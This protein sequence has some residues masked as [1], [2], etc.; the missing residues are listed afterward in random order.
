MWCG[1]DR[2]SVKRGHGIWHGWDGLRW[3]TWGPRSRLWMKTIY[4]QSLAEWDIIRT[5][6]MHFKYVWNWMI[7]TGILEHG[8]FSD[9]C[10]YSFA[11]HWL[12]PGYDSRTDRSS[13]ATRMWERQWSIPIAY[14]E[15]QRNKL[16]VHLIFNFLQYGCIM[17]GMLFAF[18]DNTQFDVLKGQNP[19]L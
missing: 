19:S 2:V 16:K 12:K 4:W 17:F 7:P 9:L 3:W 8:G 6:E 10:K 14:Q 11:T 1:A 18:I 5:F 15:R 13:W